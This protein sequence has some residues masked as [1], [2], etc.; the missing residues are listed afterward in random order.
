MKRIQSTE[1]SKFSWRQIP[2]VTASLVL[3]NVGVYLA[4]LIA[5][6]PW[7]ATPEQQI[8][9]GG[10]LAVLTLTGDY[11]RLASGLFLHAG[12]MHLL[13]NMYFLIL[14]GP[15]AEREFGQV[16]MSVI[17]LAGGV[18]ASCASAWWLGKNAMGF[19][20][21]GVPFV[22]L[23]VST[24]A[25][26]AIMA[27]CGALLMNFVRAEW[28]GAG[29][30]HEPGFG[31]ALMQVVGI[32]IVLGLFVQGT[33]QAAHVGGLIAGAL[34]ALSVGNVRSG[35]SVAM[36]VARLAS[37][38]LFVGVGFWV[39][40]QTSGMTD[41]HELRARIEREAN[42]ARQVAEQEKLEETQKLLA[43]GK[44]SNFLAPSPSM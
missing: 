14:V 1:K 41:L 11:W 26:G 10:N 12:A 20:L 8:E 21:L 42:K 33:D 9:W 40:L 38:A 44:R 24:G 7:T 22:Q 28:F 36:R 16:R 17:Y 39:S 30:I 15:R 4:Q 31:K 6:L 19:D 2:P 23:V 29:S 35:G 3:L 37:P 18:L 27:V 43:D 25:S 32:N 34:L 13:M 5:G